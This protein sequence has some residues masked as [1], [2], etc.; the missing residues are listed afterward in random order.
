MDI[1]REPHELFLQ[2]RESGQDSGARAGHLL[3]QM[4]RLDGRCRQAL[5]QVVVHLPRQPAPLLFLLAGP[6][7]PETGFVINLRRIKEIVQE[8]IVDD[9]D[10]RNLTIEVP[11]MEGTIT[12]TENLVVAIWTR[13]LGAFP[14]GVRLER[15]VLWETSNNYV[16]YTGG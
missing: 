15:L 8:R 16:E 9:V 10:H 13:L 6:V 4:A 7:D 3:L 12:S 11:W 1:V 5:G 14:E 2:R